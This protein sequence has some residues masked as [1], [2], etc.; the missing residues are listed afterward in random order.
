MAL[1]DAVERTKEK[2]RSRRDDDDV[3]NDDVIDVD[4]ELSASWRTPRRIG[5]SIDFPWPTAYT[6]SAAAV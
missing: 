1:D 4:D 2:K 5:N 6:R 3:D